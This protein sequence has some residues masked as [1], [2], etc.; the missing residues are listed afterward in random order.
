MKKLHPAL[1]HSVTL[2]QITAAQ[3]IGNPRTY[4]GT[5]FWIRTFDGLPALITNRH[6]LDPV[7]KSPVYNGYFI[8]ELKVQVRETVNG[9]Y[10]QKAEFVNLI[11]E[12]AQGFC[13]L[14]ADVT[15]IIDPK[16]CG[17]VTSNHYGFEPI[18]AIE[19]ADE[20]FFLNRCEMF[21]PVGF[22]GY[23]ENWFNTLSNMSIGRTAFLASYPEEAYGNQLT[24]TEDVI[25]VSG[26]SFKGSSGSPVFSQPKGLNIESKNG[27]IVNS[28]YVPPKL[29]GIMSGH[30]LDKNVDSAF[31]EH[32]GL[33]YFT[34]STA[35][36]DLLSKKNG[37][38][39]SNFIHANLKKTVR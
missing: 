13:H 9:E 17:N 7:L 1:K 24:K 32:S 6:I 27:V 19:L 26:L 22:L 30:Y 18:I 16:F 21:D 35:I 29:I 12:E 15:I 5:G 38:P 14:T 4:N 39:V 23:P 3:D 34:R 11:L 37:I 20:D 25:L 10:S 31:S 2:L 33:S 8:E 28:P 36:L